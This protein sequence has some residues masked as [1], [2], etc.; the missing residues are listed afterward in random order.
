MWTDTEIEVFVKAVKEY[1]NDYMMIAKA[2]KTKTIEQVKKKANN[3]CLGKSSDHR[4][5]FK[6]VIKI[7]R[8][9]MRVLDKW[10]EKEKVRLNKALQ[11]HGKDY[12]K[13]AKQFDGKSRY[14]VSSYAM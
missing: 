11:K 8:P 7:L 2:V 6:A 1:R 10:T 5:D 4:H 9:T 3:I 13:I 12:N 14:Q